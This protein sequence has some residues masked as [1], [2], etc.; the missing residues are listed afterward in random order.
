[1]RQL[2]PSMRTQMD[3]RN[4]MASLVAGPPVAG[5]V[6]PRT[7]AAAPGTETNER[8]A[9]PGEQGRALVRV[10][11]TAAS[12]GMGRHPIE[13]IAVP[14]YLVNALTA[15]CRREMA[16]GGRRGRSLTALSPPPILR[17]YV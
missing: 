2:A 5:S 13:C 3:G 12:A 4:G 15:E 7:T 10:E 8:H 1:M 14:L 11:L 6:S 16:S 9:I 17:R